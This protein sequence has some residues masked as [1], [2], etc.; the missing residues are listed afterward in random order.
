GSHL[1]RLKDARLGENGLLTFERRDALFVRRGRTAE[2][3]L[4]RADGPRPRVTAT[5]RADDAVY[6]VTV[7]SGLQGN[8]E[9]GMR[10]GVWGVLERYGQRLEQVEPGDKIVFY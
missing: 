3:V 2:A 9:I 4:F 6:W 8:F 7:G 1:I 5:V 10:H